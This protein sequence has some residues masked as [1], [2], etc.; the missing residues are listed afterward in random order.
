MKA[1]SFI[2]FSQRASLGVVAVCWSIFQPQVG[3]ALQKPEAAKPAASNSLAP[4]AAVEETPEDRNERITADRFLD[5]LKKRPRQG[6]A[7]DK[8]YGYH[9][10]HGTLDAFATSL[11]QEAAQKNDGNLWMVL[12]MAQ[13]LRGQDALAAGSLEKAEKLMPNEPLVSYYLGKTQ[14]LL[15]E[16][17]RAAQSMQR[18][19][20][21]KPPRADMLQIFKDLGRIFQR[22]GRNQDALNVWKQLETS[23][24]GDQKIQEEIASILAEEGAREAALERY[25]ALAKAHKDRS[26]QLEMSIRAAVLRAEL[27]QRE[28]A[29]REFERVLQAVNPDSWLHRDVRRRIDEVFISSG[30]YD[31]LLTYYSKWI[32]AHPEDVDGMMRVGR[33]MSVQQRPV[34]AKEWFSKAIAKAPSQAEPRLALVEALVIERNFKV[35]VAE[36]EALSKI[37]PDNLDRLMRWGELVLSDTSASKP[38][39]QKKAAEI[40]KQML[41]KR[42]KDPVTVARV[43]DLLR[44]AEQT[45]DAIEQYVVAIK[46]A[47]S[48]S[49]YREY[50]GEYFHRLGRKDEAIATWN[51][52]AAGPR[53]NRDNRVRLAEVYHTFGYA[54]EAL[55]E[56]DRACK[57]KPTFGQRSRYAELL[58]EAKEFDVALEQIKLAESIA[59]G[60]DERAI[61][62][63]ERIKNYQASGKLVDRIAEQERACEGPS[64]KDF[65]AWQ[66]LALLREADGKTQPASLAI[67]KACEL[68]PQSIDAW[69]IAAR[70]YDRS[71]RFGEAR[72]AYRKLATMDRRFKTNYLTQIASLEMRLG[73][74]ESA[75]KSGEELLSAAPGNSDNFR[76]FAD[77]CF[78]AGKIDRGL[79]VLRRNMRG[80][81]NNIDAITNLAKHLASEMQTDE[82]IELYWR[83]FEAAKVIDG[84]YAVIAPMVE[85]YFR[86]NRFETLLT[87][88][89]TIGREE[90][91]QRDATLWQVAAHQ[92]AGDLGMARQILERLV[93][94]DTRDPKL[95]EQLVSLSKT[96]YDFEAA[97]DYQRRLNAISPS[98][99][100]EFALASMLME[101]GQIDEAEGMWIKLSLRGDKSKSIVDLVDALLQKEQF[102]T[103]SLLAERALSEQPDNWE[104]FSPAMKSFFR[105]GKLEQ[106]LKLAER[107]LSMSILPE[108]MTEKYKEMTKKLSANANRSMVAASVQSQSL[109]RS[110]RMISQARQIRMDL[111]PRSADY[112]R[113][114]RAFTPTCFGD[115]Q[116]VAQS[117]L[118]V[119]QPDG[120]NLQKELARRVA[121]AQKSKDRKDLWLA[122]FTMVWNDATLEY[123]GNQKPNPEY[124]SLL[125]SLVSLG[126]KDASMLRLSS[127]MNSR[128]R[129]VSNRT[130]ATDPVP[131]QQAELDEVQQ[132]LAAFTE[133]STQSYYRTWFAREL[134]IAGKDQQADDLLK[135]ELEK[136][137][138]AP[139]LI[140]NAG[141]F[142]TGKNPQFD[143][144]T[145][146]IEKAFQLQRDQP[147]SQQMSYAYEMPSLVA[148]FANR[149]TPEQTHMLFD[150][151]LKHQATVTAQLRPSERANIETQ[152]QQG[153]YIINGNYVELSTNF[154]P[155]SGY[156]N[157]SSINTLRAVF[158]IWKEPAQRTKLEQELMKW[159]S[160]PSDDR[161]L[162]IARGMALLSLQSWM[163][164]SAG[165]LKTI[166]SLSQKERGNE[167]LDSIRVR[168]LFDNGQSKQALELIE[169]MR[170]ANQKMLVDR[171]LT[172]LQ[173][174]LQLGDLERARA[175]A[176]KLF[177]LRLPSDT[178]FKLA[179]LMYKLGMKE[180]GD[181]MMDR[182]QRRAGGKQDTLV[183]LMNR[184]SNSNE[185]KRAVEI[186]RSLVRR[187]SPRS[188]ANSYTSENLVHEQALRVL[189]QTKELEPLIVQSAAQ[190]AR[191]PKSIKLAEQLASY[192]EAA[193]RRTEAEKVRLST[194]KASP[195]D[196]TS[197]MAAAKTL[198]ASNKHA[199]AIEKFLQ[200]LRKSPDLLE[201]G[202]N[203]MR[204]SFQ[205]TK[206][207]GKL[208]DLI[209]E[210]GIQKL[211]QSSY[212]LSQVASELSRTNDKPAINKLLMIGAK[213]GTWT[214]LSNIAQVASRPDFVLEPATRE[215]ILNRL[216]SLDNWQDTSNI[217]LIRGYMSKGRVDSP[218][219]NLV[220]LV[221]KDAQSRDKISGTMRSRLEKNAD[222]VLPR[223]IM[224]SMQ[225]V[226]KEFAE[227]EKTVQPLMT[228]KVKDRLTG[229]AL[230]VLAG[231]LAA[232]DGDYGLATKLLEVLQEYDQNSL[233]VSGLDYNS[234]HGSLLCD[235][236]KQLGR[237]EE[238]VKMV[239]AAIKATKVDER[240]NQGN[241]GYG[242]YQYLN[243]LKSLVSTLLEL[244]RPA[245]AFVL[246]R[247]ISGDTKKIQAANQWN[248]GDYFTQELN[249][250]E[251]TIM[252]K[253][254]G[255]V[256]KNIVSAAI[257]LNSN[258]ASS[259]D[260][261]G[262]LELGLK[263]STPL[264]YTVS[265]ALADFSDKISKDE[266][267]KLQLRKDLENY[268]LPELDAV[269]LK[270]LVSV[271]L[272]SRAVED[273][274]LTDR[275]LVLLSAWIA[276]PPA[277]KPTDAGQLPDELVL[278]SLAF[279]LAADAKYGKL[280]E[281][282]WERC[283]VAARI[284]R[285]PGLEGTFKCQLAKQIA[286]TDPARA[287]KLYTEALDQVLPV[288]Q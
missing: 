116:A 213:D 259:S 37:D 206:S 261:Q 28:N 39:A 59:E 91:K 262:V 240:M 210:I 133:D 67:E 1:I 119:A 118:L 153:Y 100:G 160:E 269:D 202:Y 278:G 254:T 78:Q 176:Q 222:D 81:P 271:A 23:F 257:G 239:Q 181:R 61:L 253:M 186:A 9:V 12:G 242:E 165:A 145:Q 85:L 172:I 264:D 228:K 19:I 226:N 191:S 126:D 112:N 69:T 62:V 217:S 90:N 53:E 268:K 131:M 189:A 267:L 16:V 170:P 173:L 17:D 134:R 57:L 99:Q 272:I 46:L 29:L 163:E 155:P 221:S 190:L 47:E 168:M 224:A 235:C 51:E 200:A 194:A 204:N 220:A 177:A 77:L 2:Q 34:E 208:V 154:P 141:M 167:F 6:T 284:A 161:F 184:Y 32:V 283:I 36:M 144:A 238:A 256:M 50:L 24:P 279:M 41:A 70:V 209:E 120:F 244:D 86:S 111:Q 88:L 227:V 258:P 101:L 218:L 13:M 98:P 246:H 288:S 127:L 174:V 188:S 79:E 195:A 142:T 175:S 180:L 162:T 45:E 103:A 130:E 265:F 93:R 54:K 281:S 229:N 282:M 166:D 225:I 273:T 128:Q 80:N 211:G 156:F 187:T 104:L 30:D 60:P 48:D 280:A 96:E 3:C 147:K 75:L 132:L 108:T 252:T 26:R 245:E 11:E 270:R 18:A 43:A 106:A 164:N 72:D 183:Q 216:T 107:C 243:S 21:R 40:W 92:A 255:D 178:E 285:T 158:N 192:Y 247:T 201:R 236:Y 138:S 214:D 171:E 248:S 76:F 287:T 150:L 207:W 38:A 25:D 185:P 159:N 42:G 102:D 198:S 117:I 73:D 230:W 71:G 212:R 114:S 275:S 35:A 260:Y 82:A 179:D 182:I 27:G 197:L 22:T 250:L 149:A 274:A 97:A 52:I 223:S 169:S 146:L 4:N 286:A 231:Q 241:P 237:K 65:S 63:A 31:G 8:V 203:D 44:S 199:E 193:G 263:N 139:T 277:A 251:G 56:M 115:V 137:N 143:R 205:N 266:G 95:L 58:R 89:E 110:A 136:V 123:G 140:S 215:L 15:G 10:G 87:R 234:M 66:L 83:A 157:S 219:M 94:E 232:K 249:R 125:S 276:K 109:G 64:A 129:L 121:Q 233:G 84:K 33:M 113:S 152:S 151:I 20:D 122:L 148:T 7:L 14:V 105:S 49:Q 5:V 196:P 55:A 74:V 124:E 135:K 68:A